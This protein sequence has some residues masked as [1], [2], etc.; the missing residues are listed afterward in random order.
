V[1]NPTTRKHHSRTSERYDTDLTDQEWRVIEPNLPVEQKRGRPREWPMRE[2]VNGLFYGRGTCAL[3][4]REPMDE[5]RAL[6]RL[7]IGDARP[8]RKARKRLIEC[9]RAFTALTLSTIALSIMICIRPLRRAL[10]GEGTPLG[11]ELA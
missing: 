5:E 4:F 9:P 11:Q 1:W 6:A 2:I 10:V 7:G 3:V 8:T